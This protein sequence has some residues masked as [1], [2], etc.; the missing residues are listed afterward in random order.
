MH[1]TNWNDRKINESKDQ[2]TICL[3]NWMQFVLLTLHNILICTLAFCWLN[4]CETMNQCKFI[5]K[6]RI[7]QIHK[8]F[9]K[10]IIFVHIFFFLLFCTA[11]MVFT[12][13]H[14][15]TVDCALEKTKPPQSLFTDN[16]ASS[17]FIN[18]NQYLKLSLFLWS[19]KAPVQSDKSFNTHFHPIY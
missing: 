6:Q 16:K 1:T 8:K 18:I 11:L 7:L 4:A 17:R 13:N 9:T 3:Q 2:R 15:E 5:K 10:S 19:A 12:R 14:K